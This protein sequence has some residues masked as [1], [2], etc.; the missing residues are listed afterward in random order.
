MRRVLLLDSSFAVAPIFNRLSEQFES[1]SIGSGQILVDPVGGKNHIDSNYADIKVVNEV[2][3]RLKIDSVLPGCTDASL[4]TFGAIST[5]HFKNIHQTNDK[6]EFSNFCMKH[7]LPHP[8]M[9]KEISISDYPIIVKPSDCFSGVGVS[10]VDCEE[11]L[12]KALKWAQRCSPKNKAI[13]QPFISGQ[14]YSAS[15]FLNDGKL[16]FCFVRENCHIDPFSV[17]ESYVV[18]L[19]KAIEK[20]L[21][22]LFVMIFRILGKQQRFFHIQFIIKGAKI[23]LIE[24]MLRCPGDLYGR[25]VE[26]STNFDY[27]GN[28][29]KAYIDGYRLTEQPPKTTFKIK[30]VTYKAKPGQRIPRIVRTSEHI[31]SYQTRAFNE[32]NSTSKNSRYGVAFLRK[33]I[34]F[35]DKRDVMNG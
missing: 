10:V 11:K 31:E 7:G 17:D 18:Q 19:P 16:R 30:R 32:K 4:T 13:V 1:Y 9:L 3:D 25:L 29:I 23:F 35:A 22:D 15:V 14:L 12:N 6:L 26:L 33:Q 27:F 34:L 21:Q 24:M 5:P 28:Y 8:N 20:K 2:V